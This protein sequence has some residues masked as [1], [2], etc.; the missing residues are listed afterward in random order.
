MQLFLSRLD[1]TTPQYIDI[2]SEHK[3]RPYHFHLIPSYYTTL[4]FSNSRKSIRLHKNLR[5]DIWSVRTC[6][7]QLRLFGRNRSC[8][9]SARHRI[10]QKSLSKD[11]EWMAVDQETPWPDCSMDGTATHHRQLLYEHRRQF[12]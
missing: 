7:V 5:E 10:K 6:D 11:I 1:S 8:L 3:I 4:L 2:I 12:N 9:V